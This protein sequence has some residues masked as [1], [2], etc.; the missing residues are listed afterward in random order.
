ME[1]ALA[2]NPGARWIYRQLVGLHRSR[3]QRR[4]AHGL[5]LLLNDYPALTCEKVRAAMLYSEPVMQRICSSLV[6]VGLPLR[7]G[8]G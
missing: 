3:T 7:D 4:C 5:R 1:K 8:L 2:A 6:R